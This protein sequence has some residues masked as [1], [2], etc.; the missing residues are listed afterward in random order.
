[1]NVIQL[2]SDLIIPTVIVGVIVAGLCKR[3]DVY[4][5]F[6]DGAKEGIKITMDILPSIIGLMMAI[7]MMNECGFID[8]L[9]EFLRPTLSFV[10]MPAE[11]LPLA[12][13]RPISGSA[14]IGIVGDVLSKSGADSYAG[15][16]ASV[17]MG[18]TETTFYTIALFYGSIKRKSSGKTVLV[19]LIGDVAGMLAS[20]IFCRLFFDYM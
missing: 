18:S 3:N 12:I 9:V 6:T 14:S 15:R 17:M 4:D 7:E 19:A 10:G 16:I 20:I 13:L 11:V 8:L 1:M 5:I 2:F